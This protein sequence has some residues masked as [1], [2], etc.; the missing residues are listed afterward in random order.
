[1]EHP[2]NPHSH[3]AA[4]LLPQE[5]FP[6]IRVSQR[7]LLGS[8]VLGLLPVLTALITQAFLSIMLLGTLL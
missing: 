3:L 2:E 1:M 5:P 6:P 4:L 8:G 7:P